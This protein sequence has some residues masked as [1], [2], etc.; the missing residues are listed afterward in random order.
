MKIAILTQPILMNYGGVLQAYALQRVLQNMGHDVT[1]VN[2]VWNYGQGHIYRRISFCKNMFLSFLSIIL[3]K[4][5]YKNAKKKFKDQYILTHY[6]A[7]EELKLSLTIGDNKEFLKYVRKNKFDVYIVGSDQVWRPKYSPNIY[8]YFLDFLENQESAIKMAYAA[9]FGTND[10]EY[11]DAETLHCKRLIQNFDYVSVR[12][13]SAIDVCAKYLNRTDVKWV[14]DPTL[15]LDI[16]VYRKISSGIR[17]AKNL[18]SY[19]LLDES[20]D[21]LAFISKCAWVFHGSVYNVKK[22]VSSLSYRHI[23]EYSSIE[24]WLAGFANAKFAIVD[25]FHGCVFS[26]IFHVPFIVIGNKRRGLARL[27]SI[28]QLFGLQD[29]LVY[30]ENLLDFDVTQMKEPNWHQV[31][32]VLKEKRRESLDFLNKINK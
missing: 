8:N 22:G 29:R 2:R 7:Q 21:K 12:E 28:L 11:S 9:S 10:W 16:S 4:D 14:L 3:M 31:D 13:N 1:V 26:L 27:E 32:E 20:T 19:Y 5:N 6:F 24:E 23:R 30:E 25:S 17:I 15:L 18:I